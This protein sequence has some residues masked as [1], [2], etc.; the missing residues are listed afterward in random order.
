MLGA[1]ADDQ[2]LHVHVGCVQ[3]STL[4]GRRQ[5]RDRV[6]LAGRAQVRALERVDRDVDARVGHAFAAV[7]LRRETDLLADEEHRGFVTLAFADHDRSVDRHR[8]HALAHGFDR[9]LVGPVPI[10]L[11]HR[12]G[13]RD[14]GLFDDAQ[15]VERE[16]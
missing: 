2:L 4:L 10:A 13:T 15:K 6:R 11:A 16:I 8:V 9:R 3:Q 7:L 5:H 12:V 1:R 14:G